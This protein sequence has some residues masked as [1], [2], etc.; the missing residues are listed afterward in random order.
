MSNRFGL[1]I[2]IGNTGPNKVGDDQDSDL[3]GNI[4]DQLSANF[5]DQ[6]S[7][8][9]IEDI[10]VML[11]SVALAEAIPG[12]GEVQMALQFLDFIDPYGYNQA[13]DRDSLNQIL[14]QQYQKISDS[15]ASILDCYQNGNQTS[16][17]A[18]GIS[19]AQLAAFQQ[20]D[21]SFQQKQI[22]TSTSWLTPYPPEVKYPQM[23]MC[24]LSHD[25]GRMNKYCTDPDYLADYT[26]YYNAN[27][28]QY[29]ADAAKA[30]AAAEAQ[31][32]ACI[33]GDTT[34][35]TVNTSRKTS[36]KYILIGTLVI[37][38]LVV[39]LMLKKIIP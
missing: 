23:Y 34:Q 6:K 38:S 21:P 32:A 31:I 10:A 37:I 12:V 17:D 14:T 18:V 20:R 39:F 29:Q 19:A 36:L 9:K 27:L 25:L 33:T 24:Q 26:N 7:R 35:D 1:G 2:N 8:E 30:Q 4:Y 15:Q 28:A 5:T 3:F 13:L 22:K 11:G 16:C